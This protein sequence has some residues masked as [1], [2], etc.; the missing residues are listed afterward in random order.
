MVDACMCI[1]VC[2]YVCISREGG[3]E[4]TQA[5]LHWT[6]AHPESQTPTGAGLHFLPGLKQGL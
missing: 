2:A 6:T 4:R 1:C 5:H 3:R